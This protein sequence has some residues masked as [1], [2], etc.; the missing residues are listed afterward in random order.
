MSHLLPKRAKDMEKKLEALKRQKIKAQRK[1]DRHP[2]HLLSGVFCLSAG[3]V[4]IA[5]CEKKTEF[6]LKTENQI[7][8]QTLFTLAR[9]FDGS[10]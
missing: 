2:F 5:N 7:N 10:I 9:S 3:A 8:L 4:N 6:D 1:V